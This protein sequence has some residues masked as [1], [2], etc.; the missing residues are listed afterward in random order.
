VA[1]TASDESY[2]SESAVELILTAV[3]DS[4]ATA[5]NIVIAVFFMI[6]PTSQLGL[7]FL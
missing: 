7:S 4:I 3:L 5:V 1:D 2:V 6:N